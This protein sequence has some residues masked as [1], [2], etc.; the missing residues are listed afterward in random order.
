[1]AYTKA[2]KRSVILGIALLG[3]AVLGYFS[4]LAFQPIAVVG[5]AEISG[6]VFRTYRSAFQSY[7]RTIAAANA[8]MGK[9]LQEVPQDV[10]DRAALEE[11][12][13]QEIVRQELVGVYNNDTTTKINAT[14]DAD[15]A[16]KDVAGIAKAAQQVYGLRGD[17]FRNVI[18]VPV[19]REK[20]LRDYITGLGQNYDDW[21]SDRRKATVVTF[22]S[23]TYE[24]REGKVVE[25]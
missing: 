20:M 15:M 2:V 3:I 24:W 18:L 22:P 16:G 6:G 8:E 9:T 12:I 23:G 4:Y 25:K 14:I 21:I 11:L 7:T 17:D 5:G 1:M 13:V 19:T 10:S